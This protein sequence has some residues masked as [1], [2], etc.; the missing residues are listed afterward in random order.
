MWN[1]EIWKFSNDPVSVD[2]SYNYSK[3][4]LFPNPVSDF[5]NI[6]FNSER[7]GYLEIKLYNQLG[8]ELRTLSKNI[9][10]DAKRIT[11]DCRNLTSGNYFI[12]LKSK[13]LYVAKKVIILK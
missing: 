4:T 8:I 1:R 10:I 5:L 9:G 7:Q 13:E 3:I 2:E 6:N 12:T 11:M